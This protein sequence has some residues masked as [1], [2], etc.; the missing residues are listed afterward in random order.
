MYVY[1]YIIYITDLCKIVSNI[2]LCMSRACYLSGLL[3]SVSLHAYVI[4]LDQVYYINLCALYKKVAV[5]SGYVHIMHSRVR[6]TYPLFS[7]KVFWV[8]YDLR[9]LCKT[10]YIGQL[11]RDRNYHIQ[12][13]FSFNLP[14]VNECIRIPYH[15]VYNI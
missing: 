13:V 3:V 4:G 9:V 11:L 2:N 6:I 15:E 7:E 5:W 1:I 14:N 8:L 10:T 12:S